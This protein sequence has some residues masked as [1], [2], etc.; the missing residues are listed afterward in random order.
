[1]CAAENVSYD[2]S[3]L[4]ALIFTAEGDMRHALNGLQST[5][6]GFG[7]VSSAN[8]FK[9]C[10]QPHPLKL[11]AAINSAAEGK[12]AEAVDVVMSLWN[13]GYAA[14]DIIQTLFR[15][16]RSVDLPEP[17]KLEFLK[18]IGFSHMRISEGLNTQLQLMG[19]VSRLSAIRADNSKTM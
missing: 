12:T 5:V 6:S 11:K 16:T 7:H 13:D 8:V 3:G 15:V 2:E 10:D 1:V 19:C 14:T 4:E 9:V 17:I 18:E